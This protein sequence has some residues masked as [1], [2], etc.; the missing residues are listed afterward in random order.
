[1]D[2]VMNPGYK[3]AENYFCKMG[4]KSTLVLIKEKNDTE[5][6]RIMNNSG[7]MFR[8]NSVVCSF[9]RF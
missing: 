4:E 9:G 3:I 1:M 2:V 8:T 6:N 7:V 5:P